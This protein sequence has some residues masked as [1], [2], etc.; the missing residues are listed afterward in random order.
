MILLFISNFYNCP[1][2]SDVHGKATFKLSVSAGK[3]STLRA[4]VYILLQD[5]EIVADSAKYNVQKCFKNEVSLLN[6][7]LSAF[8]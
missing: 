3:S 1:F 6:I 2:L 5:G 4:L 8:Y 7:K